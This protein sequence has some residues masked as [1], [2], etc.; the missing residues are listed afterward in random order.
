MRL[1]PDPA[2]SH[3]GAQGG[4]RGPQRALG[5]GNAPDQPS[6]QRES[7][8]IDAE[9]ERDRQRDQQSRDRRTDELTG[10]LFDTP[11]LP[12][13]VFEVGL[14]HDGGQDSLGGIV[15]QDLGGAQQEC[16]AGERK[17]IGQ[18]VARQRQGWRGQDQGDDAQ[19]QQQ[20]KPIR[21]HHQR[22]AVVAVGDGPGR[23][24][25]Q[26]PREF[27]GGGDQPDQQRVAGQQ[28]G[29]PGE[30]ECRYPVAQIGHG[31]GGEQQ[32]VIAVS[33]KEHRPDVAPD[34]QDVKRPWLWRDLRAASLAPIQQKA[35]ICRSR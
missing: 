18:G 32:A 10:D 30:G 33:G 22:A 15:T 25:E 34:W 35:P 17:D 20:A 28:C 21:A 23:D 3:F 14:R 7:D 12:V 24:R 27:S 13:C 1:H 16:E 6:R 31:G 11:Q 5:G 2:F 26:Q 9:G 8:R 4:G 29:Q 19:C